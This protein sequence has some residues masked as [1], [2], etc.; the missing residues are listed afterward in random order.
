MRVAQSIELISMYI[1]VNLK[2]LSHNPIQSTLFIRTTECLAQIK[3]TLGLI[4]L[5]L[6][7]KHPWFPEESF[8]SF[9][10]FFRKYSLLMDSKDETKNAKK[11][12]ECYQTPL[13]PSRGRNVEHL[14]EL[15]R[16]ANAFS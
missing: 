4:E 10:T 8:C 1:T 7:F 9:W 12:F 13:V 11:F 2:V 14:Q 3:L 6:S 16:L 5:K 15:T